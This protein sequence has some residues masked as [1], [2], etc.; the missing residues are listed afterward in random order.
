[1]ANICLSKADGYKEGTEY[2]AALG[3][4]IKNGLSPMN[5]I[6]GFDNMRFSTA[7]KTLDVIHNKE[8]K[9]VALVTKS[10]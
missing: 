8:K 3:D 1:M 6:I 7:D 5:S 2:S 9:T 10:E 4:M